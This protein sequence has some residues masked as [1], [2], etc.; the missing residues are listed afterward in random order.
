MQ[1]VSQI[2]GDFSVFFEKY[3]CTGQKKK[4]MGKETRLFLT[5]WISA[6]LEEKPGFLPPTIFCP[7]HRNSSVISSRNMLKSL[8]AT[9]QAQN[10]KC[11]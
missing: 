9:K 1:I 3:L 11:H 10:S 2:R 6:R 4:R 7:V 5:V 8:T